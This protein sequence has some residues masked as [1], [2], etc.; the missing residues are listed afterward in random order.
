M[1]IIAMA[2]IFGILI[3]EASPIIKNSDTERM[4]DSFDKQMSIIPTI[5]RMMAM[6]T[7]SKLSQDK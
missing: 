7:L 3:A 1:I 5:P 6:R 2:I 4:A